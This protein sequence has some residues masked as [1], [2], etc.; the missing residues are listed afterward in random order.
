MDD[1]DKFVV[2]NNTPSASSKA[3]TRSHLPVNIT[4]NGRAR[5][6]PD[7][8]VS[9]GRWHVVLLFVQRGG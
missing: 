8:Y 9:C 5:N 2:I 4:A 6:Y 1:M 7:G 3:K